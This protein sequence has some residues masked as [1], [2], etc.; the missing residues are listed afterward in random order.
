MRSSGAINNRKQLI[1]LPGWAGKV[2]HSWQS[3]V[4]VAPL[5]MDGFTITGSSHCGSVNSPR[6]S[7]AAVLILLKVHN[8]ISFCL[9]IYLLGCAGSSLQRVGSRSLTGDG[10]P[11]PPYQECGVLATGL[12]GKPHSLVSFKSVSL[13]LT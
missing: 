5:H 4:W 11:G 12:P 9:N 2:N 6:G 10:T 8:L 7:L 3:W 13:S 1:H